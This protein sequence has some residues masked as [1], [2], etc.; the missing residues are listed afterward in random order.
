MQGVALLDE[1]P[2]L[3]LEVP[4]CHLLAHL[5]FAT[6]DIPGPAFPAPAEQPPADGGAA[7]RVLGG[8]GAKGAAERPRGEVAGVCRL[9]LLLGVVTVS[10]S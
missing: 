3:R 5:G 4:C 8:G 9:G 1:W 6:C 10:S 2:S 7:C